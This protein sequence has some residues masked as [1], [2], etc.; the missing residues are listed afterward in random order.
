MGHCGKFGYA[1]W[2]NVPKFTNCYVP[3][4]RIKP[5]KSA[6]SSA[7]NL[8]MNCTP[9]R[10]FCFG[11]RGYCG[12]FCYALWAS[13]PNFIPCYK[14]LHQ[15]WFKSGGKEGRWHSAGFC[16]A[17]WPS[18]RIW[19]CA[20]GHSAGFDFAPWVIEHNPTEKICEIF[21]AL[22]H[23]AESGSALWA[24][25]QVRWPQRRTTWQNF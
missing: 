14:P 22:D 19:F 15:I 5:E 25:A 1:L 6:K 11:A 12:G 17:L 3:L 2:V 16:S 10:W 7:E 18:R 9:L 13:A 4:C 21:C 20:M 8:V 24:I 23:C